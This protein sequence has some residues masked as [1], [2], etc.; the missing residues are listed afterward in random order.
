[1]LDDRSNVQAATILSESPIHP[2]VWDSHTSNPNQAI[3]GI[4][5]HPADLN[6]PGT[7]SLLPLV[8]SI[9]SLSLKRLSW[10]DFA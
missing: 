7:I 1:M 6:Y 8:N 5:I 10:M 9:W 2:Q 3:H 4:P